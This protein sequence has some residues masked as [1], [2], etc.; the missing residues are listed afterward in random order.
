[1]FEELKDRAVKSIDENRYREHAVMVPL[2]RRDGEI[3]VLFEVRASGL[4]H[5]PDEICFPGGGRDPGESSMETAVRET[6]EELMIAREQIHVIAQM[7]TLFTPHQLKI[8]VYMC[9]LTD[10]EMT[11]SEAEVAEVFTVPLRFFLETKPDTYTNTL[12]LTPPEDFPFDKIPGGR[13]YPW[14]RGHSTVYFYYYKDYVIW[15]L[16]AYMMQSVVRILQ[17]ETCLH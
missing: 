13:N 6:M 7:D 8:S 15:G 5:Q 11:F 16:T 10:Y 14:R 4:K 3:Q 17:E 1:M 9:E 12:V 2:L